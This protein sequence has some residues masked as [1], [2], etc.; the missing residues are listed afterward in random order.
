M[1][2]QIFY[3][4][5]MLLL[6]YGGAVYSELVNSMPNIAESPDEN[7]RHKTFVLLYKSFYRTASWVLIGA[8][9]YLLTQYLKL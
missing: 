4:I 6:A 8:A 1:T 7:F 2:A 9:G 3:V 5:F